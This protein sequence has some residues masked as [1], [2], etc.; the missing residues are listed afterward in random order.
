MNDRFEVLWRRS[1]NTGHFPAPY[2]LDGDG[3]DEIV[4][5][6]TGLKPD[7]STLF[8]VG[9]ERDHVDEIVIGR[10]GGKDSPIQVAVVAG[11]EGYMI[12]DVDGGIAHRELLGHMQRLSAAP[13]RED[14]E[15]LQF[16]VTTY[17]G[18]PGIT[19][20]HD[21]KGE[22]LWFREIPDNGQV[23][24]PVD[25]SAECRPL[26]LI[27]GCMRYGGMMDGFGRRVVRFPDDGHP[28][29]C[30]DA[31]DLLG[32]GRD[33]VLLWDDDTLF[34]YG[35]EDIGDE[36]STYRRFPPEWNRSNY[37]G[38]GLFPE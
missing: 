11:N 34:V 21:C 3:K 36:P 26:C 7:G 31:T 9:I 1:L 19:S 30:A 18:E 29:L 32:T 22:R 4:V 20:F 37:R 23:L 25:W 12:W 33:Q 35:A 15:G 8:D 28:D 6:Y 10:F 38:E 14:L 27:N 17:W 2:D 16:F 13:Y 24:C 5:G